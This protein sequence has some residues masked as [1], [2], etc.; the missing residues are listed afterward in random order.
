MSEKI[1]I[2]RWEPTHRPYLLCIRS[3]RTPEYLRWLDFSKP[4]LWDLLV[5]YHAVPDGGPDL[6]PEMV[7]VGGVN[8]SLAFNDMARTYPQLMEGYKAVCFFDDDLV[9]R[10]DAV[11]TAFVTFSHYGLELAQ[12]ALTH[13]SHHAFR[14]T[15]HHPTFVLRFTNFV[16]PMMPIFSPSA[17]KVCLPMVGEA[18]SGWGLEFVWPHLLGNPKDK[19]AVIDEVQVRH[20]KA[21]DTKQGAFYLFLKSM[22]VEP[23]EERQRLFAKYGLREDVIQYGGIVRRLRAPPMRVAFTAPG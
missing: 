6:R 20:A 9:V 22:N 10:F 13:D 15:L 5:N 23:Q 16:E 18:I 14:V 11:D 19:V 12:P 21:V 4:R 2:V 1:E 17:L 3:G 8:K 7:A